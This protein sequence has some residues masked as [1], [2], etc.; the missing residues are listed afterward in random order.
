MVCGTVLDVERKTKFNIMAT[1]ILF[2]FLVS[3][4]II[5]RLAIG[6]V[7]HK[8]LPSL[9]NVAG[10]GVGMWLALRVLALWFRK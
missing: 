5:Q 1:I 9:F 7:H 10:H 4:F 2:V 8:L 6:S 3:W